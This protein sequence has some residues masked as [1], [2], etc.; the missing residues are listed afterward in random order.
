MTTTNFPWDDSRLVAPTTIHHLSIGGRSVLFCE[1]R[2]VLYG[3]NPTADHIWR[4]LAENGR[5][6]EAR[7]R[8]ADLGVT[9]EDAQAYVQDVTL[10]WLHGGQLAPQEAVARLGQRPDATRVLRIDELIVRI[11][12]FD[13][14]PAEVDAVFGQFAADAWSEAL[15]LSIVACGD[16][17][18]VFEG[19]RPIGSFGV[20]E[21][22]P[23]LKAT[24]TEHYAANVRG[25]FLMHA[26]FLVRNDKGILLT[27][28]PGAGKTTLCVALA[29]S[30]WDDQGD[31][32]VRLENSGKAVGT[33][34][35]ACVKSDAWPLVAPYAPEIADLPTYR[36]SDGK[37]VLYL[38]TPRV[39]RRPR[40]I[41]FVLLLSRQ[42]GATPTLEP[43]EP[44]DAFSTRLESAF[45]AKG[46]IAA[47]ALKTF[48]SA[49]EGAASFRFVYSN[50]ADAIGALKDLTDE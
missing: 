33:P 10:S 25:A 47:P 21:W 4:S 5:P 48:A 27:G 36:R 18:F 50:L 1:A 12:F 13:V 39:A 44:L 43:V 42:P 20:G 28:A 31:D 38:P 45:S 26:A 2:Q 22:V 19:D 11:N 34:F 16:R 29:K 32:I 9:D 14:A 49:I 6:L 46:A 8:L 7:R 40:S 30:G 41:D 35:A 23:Q 24:M 17:I 15:D 3:L 37:D